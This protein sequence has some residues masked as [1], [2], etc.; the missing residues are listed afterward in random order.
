MRGCS[1]VISCV[2]QLGGAETLDRVSSQANIHA[3]DAAKAAAVPRFVYMSAHHYRLPK[4]L[5]R[6]YF[7]GKFK[8]EEALQREYGANGV[9]IRPTFVFVRQQQDTA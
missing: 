1:A 6:G 5:Q 8:V 4:L 9:Q 3:I 7:A 2:I